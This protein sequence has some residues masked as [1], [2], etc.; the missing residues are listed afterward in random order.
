MCS[1]YVVHSIRIKLI[2]IFSTKVV[3]FFLIDNRSMENSSGFLLYMWQKFKLFV[4]GDIWIWKLAQEIHN[5]NCC[6]YLQMNYSP[7]FTIAMFLW[8]D[9]VTNM[10]GHHDVCTVWEDPKNGWFKTTEAVLH[11][12]KVVN[13]TEKIKICLSRKN[14]E[15][16]VIKQNRGSRGLN[17]CKIN[18]VGVAMLDENC[19]PVLKLDW[20]CNHMWFDEH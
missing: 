15:V 5:F 3:A 9:V 8:A 16:H 2:V 20:R 13:Q 4:Q 14:S 1:C 10:T 7:C 6:I 17:Y 19:E 11:N 12:W 18:W